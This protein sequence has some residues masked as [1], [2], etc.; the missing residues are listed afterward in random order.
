MH[1]YFNYIFNHLDLVHIK[2]ISLLGIQILFYLYYLYNKYYGTNLT[3]NV[4]KPNDLQ[5]FDHW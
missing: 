3:V 2:D 5:V 1:H 4:T